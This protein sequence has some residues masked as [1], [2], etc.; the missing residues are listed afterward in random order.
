MSCD[1]NR[2][3]RGLRGADA[4]VFLVMASLGCATMSAHHAPLG[5]AY[6]PRPDGADVEVFGPGASPGQCVRVSRLDVHI[7]KT[8]FAGS[9][10]E[11]ALP[12]LKQ[13]AR[14]SGADAITEIEEHTSVRAETRMYHATAVGLLCAAVQQP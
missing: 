14:L 12:A 11:E 9:T 8:M 4:M 13:E 5:N 1:E 2:A 10:L 7:E 6:P 3:A